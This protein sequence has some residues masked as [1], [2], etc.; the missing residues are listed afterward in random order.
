MKKFNSCCFVF[1]F[2]SVNIFSQ[3]NVKDQSIQNDFQNYQNTESSRNYTGS[4]LTV[5]KNKEG[6][7]G[8]RYLFNSWVN[9]KVTD[10]NDKEINTNGYSFNYDKIA[11]K[12]LATP[13]K[14]TI[15]E[16][17]DTAINSYS[18]FGPAGEQILFKKI[19]N[20]DPAKFLIV[21]AEGS[22]NTCSL[23][24]SLKTEFVKASFTSNGIIQSGNKYDEYVDKYEYYI[25]FS[26]SKTFTKVELKERSIKKVLA[27]NEEKVKA[28]FASHNEDEMNESLLVKLIS[29]L[30]QK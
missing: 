1:L 10:K 11:G 29:Y 23:Y 24:K 3:N 6:T 7:V 5:F 2:Y 9:G 14:K 20:I 27:N 15:I 30:N 13:D 12:L 28:F 22:G 25:M 17:D 19:K 26:N 21:L 4:Y 16:I 18:F 8:S